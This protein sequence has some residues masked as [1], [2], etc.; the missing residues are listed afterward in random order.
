MKGV[1][2]MVVKVCGDIKNAEKF[3]ILRKHDKDCIDK[4]YTNN[5]YKM[6]TDF[7]KN[8]TDFNLI[9][10]GVSYFEKQSLYDEYTIM[11]TPYYDYNK[12][13]EKMRTI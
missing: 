11:F 3:V 12:I 1:D 13:S 9:P 10:N 7:F 2:P 8:V 5:S 4:Y 6:F